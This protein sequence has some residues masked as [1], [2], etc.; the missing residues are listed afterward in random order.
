V[1]TGFGQDVT[2]PNSGVVID[3]FAAIHCDCLVSLDDA[4]LVIVHDVSPSHG[5]GIGTALGKGSPRFLMWPPSTSL[6]A[7]LQECRDDDALPTH[8]P[9]PIAH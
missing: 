6:A 7:M 4:D 1:V 2:A 3:M 5:M 8:H 9:K